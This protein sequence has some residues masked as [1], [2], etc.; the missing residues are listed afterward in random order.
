MKTLERPSSEIARKYPIL[1]RW[2]L[3]AYNRITD[4][5]EPIDDLNQ[6]ISPTP[7]QAEVQALSDKMDELLTKL[8]DAGHL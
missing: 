2:L 1:F 7:T 5:M 8:R 3:Q 4:K 6:T